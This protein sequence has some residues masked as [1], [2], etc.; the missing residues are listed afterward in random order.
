MDLVDDIDLEA[1]R[2]RAVPDPLDD[3]ARVVDTRM[4]CR[5]DFQNIHMAAG[6]NG[7][8][9]LAGPARLQRGLA[10]SVL[11]DAVQAPG[12]QPCRRGLAHTADTGQDK[13]MGEAAER[14]GIAKRPDQRFLADQLGKPV[15][16]VL[17][18]QYPIAVWILLAHDD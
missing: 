5:V 13:G 1:G 9:W 4:A 18:C 7:L 10:V 14:K 2:D 16:P 8:A 6:A 15:W 3:F 12:Q 17:A 11:A